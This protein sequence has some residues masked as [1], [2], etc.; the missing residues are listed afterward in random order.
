MVSVSPVIRSA[1]VPMTLAA[2]LDTST[3]VS[4]SIFNLCIS[5][6]TVKQV[7]IFVRLAH[8]LL[9]LSAFPNNRVFDF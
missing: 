5:F 9:S 7:M 1:L 2:V 4:S 3:K 6:I 8:S